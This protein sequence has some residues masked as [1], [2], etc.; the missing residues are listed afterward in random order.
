MEETLEDLRGGDL[1][2]NV[3]IARRVLDGEPGAPRD[4]VALNAGAA[5]Y[6][7]G[8]A[9][10]LWKGVQDARLLLESGQARAKL[11][12]IVAYTQRIA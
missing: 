2:D 11:D 8:V 6:V 7:A 4:A 9:D 3:A 1:D 10:D 12:E 5:L